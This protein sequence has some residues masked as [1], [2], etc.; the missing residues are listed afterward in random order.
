MTNMAT[1]Q[2]KK[3]CPEGHKIYIMVDPSLVIITMHLIVWTMPQGREEH[4]LCNTSILHF[5]PHNYP[6]NSQFKSCLLT[7]Q[8]LHAKFG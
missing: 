5:L 7:L 6:W 1:P 3:P 8:M 4:F 2:H